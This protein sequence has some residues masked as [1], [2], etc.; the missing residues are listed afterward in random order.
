MFFLSNTRLSWRLLT[1][2]ALAMA[3]WRSKLHFDESASCEIFSLVGGCFGF[4]K[5]R[6]SHRSSSAWILALFEASTIRQKPG[7]QANVL[8]GS[9]VEMVQEMEDSV[10]R[11]NGMIC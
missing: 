10:F 1:H 11:G 8:I 4:P 9:V 5:S 7:L 6:C 3:G 2:S